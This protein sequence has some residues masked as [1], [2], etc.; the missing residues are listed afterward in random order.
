MKKREKNEDVKLMETEEIVRNMDVLYHVKRKTPEEEKQ[1]ICY[2]QQLI[3]LIKEEGFDQVYFSP[4][5]LIINAVIC[6]KDQLENIDSEI[7]KNICDLICHL[8][9]MNKNEVQM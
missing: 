3:S 5:E 1:A 8:G 9:Y 4:T 6:Y 2:M 7:D